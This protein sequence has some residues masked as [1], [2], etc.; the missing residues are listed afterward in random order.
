MR[1]ITYICIIIILTLTSGCYN[2]RKKFVRKKKYEKNLPVYVDFKEYPV[3]PSREA[4]VDYCVFIRGWLS[5]LVESLSNGDSFKRQKRAINGVIENLDQLI[6]FY[7]AD[8]KESIKSL[9]DNFLAVRREIENNPFMDT[10]KRNALI[11]RIEHL[12]RQF[13]IEFNY[14]DAKKWI[15]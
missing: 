2:V 11:K 1:K 12:K 5:D 13:E 14:V 8:G 10:I 15:N 9:Y 6:S 4:Y 3:T 7:N